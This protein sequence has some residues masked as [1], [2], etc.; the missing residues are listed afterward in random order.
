MNLKGA[1]ALVTGSNRGLGKALVAALHS[2]GCRTVYAAARD[3][4]SVAAVPGI[5]P[6]RLDITKP[7]QVAAATEQCRDVDLLINNAAIARLTPALGAPSMEDA[8]AQMETNYFGTLAMCRASAPVLKANGGGT[9]VNVLSV[10]SWFN[11]PMQGAYCASKSAAWSM[12]KAARFELRSQG[13]RVAA[14]YSGYIDT[15]MAAGLSFAK[16]SPETIAA[17]ILDG[18]ATDQEEILTDERARATHAELLKDSGPFEANM[19]RT[20]DEI[21]RA[22]G[23]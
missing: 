12:T 21:Q 23:L 13:T 6:V 5:V 16:S 20:W 18:I 8:R 22:R 14:V 7:D 1:T 4:A 3:P 17:A 9:L 19:Q 15:D 10:A 11:V 2:A